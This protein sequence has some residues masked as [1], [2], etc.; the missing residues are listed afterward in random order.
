MSNGDEHTS[1]IDHFLVSEDIY[2]RIKSV[3]IIES[4]DNASWHSPLRISADYKL[5]SILDPTREGAAQKP[6]IAWHRVTAGH[7]RQYQTIIENKLR[8]RKMPAC[9]TCRN[10]KCTHEEHIQEIND[11]CEYMTNAC[12]QAAEQCMPKIATGKPKNIPYWNEEVGQFKEDA[13]ECYWLWEAT[14]KPKSG[15]LFDDMRTSKRRY[16]Y[17]IREIK[18]KSDGLRNK[19]LA[20]SIAEGREGDLW[21]ELK[22]CNKG[23]NLQILMG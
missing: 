5:Q 8:F 16:H 12:V 4:I 17:A 21:T 11:Y 9:L 7:K 23:G 19:R 6:K 13:L 3:G 22:K 18:I 10:V 2:E 20:E 14:G 15:Q 1:I